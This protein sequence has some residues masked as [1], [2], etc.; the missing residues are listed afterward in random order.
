MDDDSPEMY[1]WRGRLGF[2]FGCGNRVIESEIVRMVPEG[3]S[4]H[5]TRLPYT[6]ISERGISDMLSDLERSVR[7]LAGGPNSVGADMVVFANATASSTRPGVDGEIIRKM[8]SAGGVPATTTLTAVV[9]ALNHL[10]VRR[11]SAALPYDKPERNLQL[12]T[13]LEANGFQVERVKSGPYIA[14]HEVSSQPPSS[15]YKL[16]READTPSSEAVVMTIPNFRTVEIIEKLETDIGKPIV[17]GNQ[18]SAWTCL[19]R[20]VINDVVKGFGRLLHTG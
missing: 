15:A 10:G 14:G 1:G 20:L 13:F 9:A 2:V 8:E 4:C 18:A 11:V 12:K 6:E 5:F 17:T 19:R 16:L 3:V 7:L